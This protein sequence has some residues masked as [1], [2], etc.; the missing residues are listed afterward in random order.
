MAILTFLLVLL[1]TLASW[2]SAEAIPRVS[3]EK[4]SDLFIPRANG[5]FQFDSNLAKTLAYDPESR[6]IYSTGRRTSRGGGGRGYL[7]HELGTDVPLGL[8]IPTL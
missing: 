8:L 7:G 4:K 3:L 2:K 1:T 5:T 6:I